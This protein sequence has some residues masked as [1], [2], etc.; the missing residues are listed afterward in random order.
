MSHRDVYGDMDTP[1]L[2]DDGALDRVL[3][4]RGQPEDA[5]L[6][7]FVEDLRETF[8]EVTVARDV[9]ERH[10]ATIVVAA[11]EGASQGRPSAAPSRSV[12]QRVRSSIAAR[13]AALTDRKS[14]V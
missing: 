13:V 11:A 9:Q 10:L 4:D 8:P 3:E 7:L 5:L 2:P 12:L 1:L 6:A 14:V